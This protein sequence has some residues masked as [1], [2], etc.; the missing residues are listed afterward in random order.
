MLPENLDHLRVGMDLSGNIR[1]RLGYA[2][3]RLSVFIQA[4]G[5]GAAVRPKTNNAIWDGG[6]LVCGAGSHPSYHP[7]VVRRMCQR[8]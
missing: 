4:Y 6:L 1:D 7:G 8:G 5:R 3:A 2:R